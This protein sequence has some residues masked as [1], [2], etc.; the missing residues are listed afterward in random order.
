[1]V[2][3][4]G[5]QCLGGERLTIGFYNKLHRHSTLGYVV[6]LAMFNLIVRVIAWLRD[7]VQPGH[8]ALFSTRPDEILLSQ[9]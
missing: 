1:M 5:G 3:V 7:V 8:H 9:E 4:W 2:N 6:P